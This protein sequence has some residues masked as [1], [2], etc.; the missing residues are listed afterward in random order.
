MEDD[1]PRLEDDRMVRWKKDDPKNS[2]CRIAKDGDAK[3]GPSNPPRG[4]DWSPPSGKHQVGHPLMSRRP[5]N[6]V[7]SGISSCSGETPRAIDPMVGQQG[8]V[9]KNV[10][11]FGESVVTGITVNGVKLMDIQRLKMK[12]NKKTV[13]NTDKKKQDKKT[14]NAMTMPSS[15][16]LKMDKFLVNRQ[17]TEKKE[18][19][20]QIVELDR[21]KTRTDTV[22]D[23]TTTLSEEEKIDMKK[24]VSDI[25]VKKT[26]D[27]HSHLGVKKKIAMF[28]DMSQ[29][30]KCV[31]GSGYCG[32][33]NVKLVR[34]IVKK[35]VSE[36]DINGKL[37][38]PMREVITLTC[39]ATQPIVR[40]G[41][42]IPA[43]ESEQPELGATNGKKAR[44]FEIVSN[45]LQPLKPSIELRED[46]PL[47]KTE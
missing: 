36:I 14:K 6:G 43:L 47:D 12:V 32:G 13:V 46:L 30:V 25:S 44:K 38:W 42:T 27:K 34:S 20:V 31:L 16:Q 8:D 4:S 17:T 10:K 5:S 23:N 9:K 2:E 3:D 11:K 29:E 21:K 15:D 18:D 22:E 41:R 33:H 45:Q 7:P 28:S 35:K 19:N 37:K 24:K 26:F 40:D 1:S 39:P